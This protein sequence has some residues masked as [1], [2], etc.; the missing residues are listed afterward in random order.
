MRFKYHLILFFLIISIFSFSQEKSEILQQRIE[1]IAETNENEEIDLTTIMDQLNY[2]LEHPLNLNF[3]SEDELESLGLLNEIQIR[4]LVLHRQLNGKFISIYELQSLKYWD[5]QT[6][7]F[8]LPF[9]KIEEKLDQVHIGLKEALKKGSYETYFRYQTIP[10]LKNGNVNVSD[11]IKMMSNSYYYG[12][13]DHYYSRFR[14]SYRTNISVGI[15][16]DKDP[17]EQFF[18]GAEKQGFDFYS[19]H[20]F[21]KGGKYLKSFA[22]GDYQV[23][24]GQGLNFWSGFAFGKT[25]EVTNVKKSATTI[26]PYTSTDESRFLRGAAVELGYK[27]FSLLLFGSKKKMDAIKDI[28]SSI[29]DEEK[30]TSI[31]MTGLHR[32]TNEIARKNE[33]TEKIGGLNL[34]YKFKSFQCG[35]ASV[36]QGYDFIYSKQYQPYN[37][38]DFRGR[39]LVS[40]SG[41]Y[42]WVIRNFNFFGEISTV[43]STGTFAQ[44]HGVLIALDSRASMSVVYRN[45]DKAYQTFYNSGFSEGT[46]TQNEK[47]IY[48]GLKL[49]LSNALTF[50]SYADYF[51]FPWLKYQVDKPSFGHEYLAQLNYKPSK[52]LEIYGRFREQL[53]Q[54]NSRDSDGTISEVE[55]VLQRNYRFNLNYAVSE[56]I[57]L[58]SRIEYVTI[59]RLSSQPE[60]GVIIAQDL[61]YKPKSLPFDVSFR[62]VLFQT[63]S[64]DSRIYMYE[65]NSPTVFSIP[66]YYYK[67][68]RG[69][70]LFRYTFLK[71]FDLWI[72]Y[73]NT[74]Y[75]N[76]TSIGTGTEAING[77]VKS[78][79]SI[80]LRM[81]F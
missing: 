41:D 13:K 73:G 9:V 38:F 57:T 51:S 36:Y 15:T 35:V 28:D 78:D 27:Q 67:G 49:K 54:K 79:I 52:K 6:I 46:N 2:F 56:S 34:K 18:K 10:Q 74:I 31:Q 37:Q 20:T 23:Q 24:I 48:V 71:K 5:L 55:D 43:S 14:Y 7:Q 21:Y 59:N 75:V 60:T 76:K 61:Q 32:T 22:L 40:T 16:G 80:Q 50:N 63:D 1:F 33:I 8:I 70:I 39:S 19:F 62:Y 45:Y 64:Y 53:R 4:D 25:S 81:K 69:Y 44:L 47:G 30:I 17:G 42:S 11:S 29:I 66:A 12:N 68:S 72:R 3:A 77:S 26:R 65:S 58:K